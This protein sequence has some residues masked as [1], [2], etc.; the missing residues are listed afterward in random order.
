MDDL[1]G[2][3][4]AVTS[5]RLVREQSLLFERLGATVTVLPLVR[6]E[7]TPEGET[8]RVIERVLREPPRIAVFS[9]G[10]GVRWLF[11]IADAGGVGEELRAALDSGYVVARGPKAR[12]ALAAA[13]LHVDWVAPGATGA[14]VAEHLRTIPGGDD[15]LF[16][17]LDGV[18]EDLACH[19]AGTI[20]LRARTYTCLPCAAGPDPLAALADVHAITFTSPVAVA[21]LRVTAGDQLD[22]VIARLAEL[23]VVAVG[24]VTGGAL[25]RLGVETVLTPKDHRL[26][27]MVRTAVAA[28]SAQTVSLADGVELKGCAIVSRAGAATL[29][30]GELRLLRA[31]ID[32]S[33]AVV[34][35]RALARLAGVGSADPHAVEAIVTRLRRRLGPAA[36]LVETVPRRGYRLAFSGV[37]VAS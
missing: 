6:L 36:Q 33:G 22:E 10:L 26:G 14:E 28:L 11:S 15:A 12:G 16:A 13:G 32:A 35:K 27:A 20:G 18:T 5:N 23:T 17:Q 31:L 3:R 9:T 34:G 8:L 7:L 24:P 1:R 4:V 2:F 29:S 19:V 37:S 25:H 21:G 30:S